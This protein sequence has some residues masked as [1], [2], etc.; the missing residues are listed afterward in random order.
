MRLS[1]KYT[2][3]SPAM[4]DQKGFEKKA[5]K[6]KKKKRTNQVAVVLHPPPT[7]VDV[8]VLEVRE[9]QIFN[10]VKTGVF[11]DVTHCYFVFGV[12]FE[13]GGPLY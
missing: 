11:I 13:G 6:K 3:C 5:K 8:D 9:E 1:S 4:M 2:K 7:R 10:V 12:W